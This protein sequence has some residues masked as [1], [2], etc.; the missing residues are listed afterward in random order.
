MCCG[1]PFTVLDAI[2]RS[3]S[4]VW[5]AG[6]GC[7]G[8]GCGGMKILFGLC[9]IFYKLAS[10]KV[11]AEEPGRSSDVQHGSG[12]RALPLGEGVRM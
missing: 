8:T 6:K 11:S 10:V 9:V 5:L 1:R 2:G 12:R 3:T 4:C 7:E